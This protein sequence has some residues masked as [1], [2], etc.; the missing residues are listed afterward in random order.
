MSAVDSAW[1]NERA[2]LVLMRRDRFP[3]RETEPEPCESLRE[4][5]DRLLLCA[6][7]RRSF[8]ERDLGKCCFRNY[9]RHYETREREECTSQSGGVVGMI[10][11]GARRI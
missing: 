5:Y 2:D 3:A 10:V 1:R 7:G 4:Y 8:V 9:F 11:S 6:R